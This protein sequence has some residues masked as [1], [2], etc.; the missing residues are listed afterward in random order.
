MYLTDF[1]KRMQQ[2]VKHL[3]DWGYLL[4][5]NLSDV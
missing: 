5:E 1:T 2:E 3:P 4:Q